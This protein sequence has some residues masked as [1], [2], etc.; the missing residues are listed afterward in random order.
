MTPASA[1][2]CAAWSIRARPPPSI[3]AHSREIRQIGLSGGKP[4]APATNLKAT[5]PRG[6]FIRPIQDSTRSPA[7]RGTHMRRL[8]LIACLVALVTGATVANANAAL[9]AGIGDQNESSFT[10]PNFKKLKVHRTRLIVA[11]DAINSASGKAQ[12]DSYMKAAKAAKL[13]VLVAFNPARSSAC[14]AKPC[15]IPSASAYTKAFKA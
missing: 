10:N 1:S 11:Y 9:K 7:G 3:S 13:K 15:S 2:G 4:P 14:P 5:L 6:S 12:L 8:V